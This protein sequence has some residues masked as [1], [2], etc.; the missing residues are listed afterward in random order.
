M[1]KAFLIAG[2]AFMALSGAASAQ[3]TAPPTSNDPAA[4]SPDATTT[5]SPAAAKDAMTT[6]SATT[7][8]DGRATDSGSMAAAAPPADTAPA[9]GA[10]AT[11]S[12]VSTA[13]AQPGAAPDAN[14]PTATAPAQTAATGTTSAAVQAEW[15]KYD[16][17]NKGSL[18][19]LEF[20]EWVMA[21]NGQDMTTQV[22]STRTSKMA[23]LPA[24][25]VLNATAGAFSKAD[26]N[27]D[28]S[29]SPDELTTFLNG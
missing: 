8:T 29:V 28:R 20:G 12:A 21:A 25:K 13:Q 5:D 6:D 10:T 15:A 27:K 9:T 2:T 1:T 16:K 7:A 3:N 26:T 19:P 18:T 17:G 24:V 14:A 4:I 22:A 11:D 23:N